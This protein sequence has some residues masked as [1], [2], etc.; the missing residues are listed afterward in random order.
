MT[1]RDAR[2]TLPEG[3]GDALRATAEEIA[4]VL[5]GVADTSVPVPGS[6]WT[7]GEAAAHLAQ[8]NELMADLAAGQE[9]GYGDGT[10]QSLAAANERALAE[11]EERA[12]EPLAGL[13]VAHTDAYLTAVDQYATNSTGTGGGAG[14]VI[15]PLGPM[16]RAVL[17][18]YLLTHMLGHGY[19]L[20]RALGC[21]HMIDR[22]RVDLSLP[23]LITAMPRVTDATNTA[24]LTADYTIRLW[25]GARFGVTF[26]DGAATAT[27][28]PPV[29]P[30]CTILIEPVTF[31]LMA[32]GR[33]DP[34]GAIACGRVFARGRK[35]WLA[36][37][38][39]GLFKAP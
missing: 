8:A 31:F 9:R 25:G 18:S 39:P 26:T 36:P 33:T 12:A 21:R 4:A 15:T 30:D 32:L 20:A 28:R 27:S 7:V 11:F 10:P 17:G 37:R 3:L 24:R 6:E 14:T 34:L 23:F 22:T 35:P 19:D 13:I 1:G 38:F 29:R 16:S 2:G 5:R